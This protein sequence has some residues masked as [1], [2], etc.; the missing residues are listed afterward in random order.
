V[1]DDKGPPYAFALANGIVVVHASMLMVLENEAQLAAVLGHEIEHSIQEHSWRQMQYHKKKLMALQI[2]GAVATGLG[3]KEIGDVAT[4]IGAAVRNGYSRSLENQADRLGLERM[5]EAGYDPREAPAVWKAMTRK[6]GDDP[7]NFFQD[8]H[9]NNATRR[10]YLMCELK[11]NYSKL[12]YSTLKTGD[13]TFNLIAALAQ[14]PRKKAKI[15]IKSS[16]STT[17]QALVKSEPSPSSA[18]APSAASPSVDLRRAAESGVLTGAP[19]RTAIPKAEPQDT[20]VPVNEPIQS[21]LENTKTLN[22][23]NEGDIE[24]GYADCGSELKRIP[25]ISSPRGIKALKCGER[26]SILSLHDNWMRIRT[27]DNQEGYVAGRFI[28]EI[29]ISKQKEQ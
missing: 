1:A 16:S 10:S 19:E 27:K 25:V 5:V 29:P 18:A 20:F 23:P 28:S 12:D 26:V 11:N 2:G 7:T 22:Q 9:D 8:R 4:L 15:K 13:E 17:Q 3:Y 24:Q 14:S 6:L 21:H